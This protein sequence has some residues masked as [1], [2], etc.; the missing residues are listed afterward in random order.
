MALPPFPFPF[1]LRV[2]LAGGNKLSSVMP[3]SSFERFGGVWKAS[4][5]GVAP[6]TAIGCEED[7]LKVREVGEEDGNP[8][9]T[10]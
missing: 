5:V 10:L 8:S 6:I 7:A 3:T 2:H 1:T 9:A 4:S